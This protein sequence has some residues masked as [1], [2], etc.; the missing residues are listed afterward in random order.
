MGVKFTNSLIDPLPQ[1]QQD[2]ARLVGNWHSIRLELNAVLE[3]WVVPEVR[4]KES[5]K[6]IEQV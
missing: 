4:Q 2:W 5:R 6:A 3:P 1:G